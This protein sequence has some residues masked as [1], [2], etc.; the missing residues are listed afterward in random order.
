V[1]ITNADASLDQLTIRGLGGDDN[2]LA[3][4]LSA[5]AIRL[6]IDGGDDEDFLVGDDIILGGNNDDF[7]QG[8]PGNDTLNGDPGSNILEQ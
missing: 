2:I 1:D 6:Q 7:L 8:G 3:N 4:G 5:D